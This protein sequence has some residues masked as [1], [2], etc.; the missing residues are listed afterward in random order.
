MLTL[1]RF[2][3]REA[4]RKRIVLAAV[5]LTVVF[6]G[7]FGF[8]THFAVR[9]LETSPHILPAFRPV[10]VSQL[11]LTGVWLIGLASA[12]LA[13]FA[14]AGSLSAEVESYTLHAIVSK[15]IGRWEIVLGKWLGLG[16]MAVAYTVVST[17]AVIAIVWLRAGYVPPS[18][19]LAV[20]SLALQTLLLLSL[21]MLGSALFPALATGIVVFM[22][23]AIAMGGGAQEQ[24]GFLLRNQTM[25]VIGVWVSLLIPSDALAKLAASAL[26][27]TTGSPTAMPGPFTVLA[28]PS[29]WMAAY[30][31]LYLLLCL[32]LA[33]ARFERQD[34]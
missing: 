14:G 22:L 5:V 31:A 17:A 20:G 6:L 10:L 16:T 23:H 33:I 13:I 8:G 28:A 18:P 27:T 2:T 11:L 34:L 15:P 1:A 29:P 24:I 7:L 3:F 9:E 32:T 4:V 12:L 25:Q 19:L 30:A 21:T 26:Q